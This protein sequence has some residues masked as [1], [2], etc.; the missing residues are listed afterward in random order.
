MSKLDYDMFGL[1]YADIVC[2]EWSVICLDY[3][4]K[5]WRRNFGALIMQTLVKYNKQNNFRQFLK[6]KE[7]KFYSN[8]TLVKH[9]ED[10]ET[11]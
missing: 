10:E 2:E 3:A 6:H 1:Y 9:K 4:G 5:A 7:D 11:K 8:N